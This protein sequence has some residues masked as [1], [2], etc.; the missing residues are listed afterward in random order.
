MAVI[1]TTIITTLALEQFY[2][3]ATYY[4]PIECG[5]HLMDTDTTQAITV[6]DTLTSAL[7][8]TT[9]ELKTTLKSQTLIL[10]NPQIENQQSNLQMLEKVLET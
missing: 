3:I 6:V 4:P 5:C 10:E 1:T 9:T 2:F 7:T 8:T